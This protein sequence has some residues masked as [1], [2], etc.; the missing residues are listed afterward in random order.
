MIFKLPFSIEKYRGHPLIDANKTIPK[1]FS[2][3]AKVIML[4]IALEMISLEIDPFL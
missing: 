2:N 4:V 3:N 1:F